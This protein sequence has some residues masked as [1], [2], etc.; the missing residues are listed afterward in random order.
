[1]VRT[2]APKKARTNNTNKRGK[3]QPTKL[4]KRVQDRLVEA[5]SKGN[6]YDA[7][8]GYAGI[9]YQ[10]LRNWLARGEQEGEGLY[11]DFFLS[12]KKAQQTAEVELVNQWRGHMPDNWQAVATFMER[13]YPE[14][15]GRRQAIELT[16]KSGQAIDI[17]HSF[18]ELTTKELRE[19]ANLNQGN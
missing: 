9:T 8:C 19:L 17:N 10:T 5:I 18:S 12:I 14:R 16:G 6:Y 13:R 11:F 1:M 2:T 7:A 4:T 15:W 3:G